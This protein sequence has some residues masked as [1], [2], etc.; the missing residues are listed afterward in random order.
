MFMLHLEGAIEIIMVGAFTLAV[1]AIYVPYFL[2]V[3]LKKQE[4]EKDGTL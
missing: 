1:T 2:H 4:E 3:Y